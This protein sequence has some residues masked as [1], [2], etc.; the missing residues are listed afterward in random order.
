[1]A[2]I[3][4]AYVQIIPTAEGIKGSLTNIL[5]SE[6]GAAG[7]SAGSKFGGG[8]AGALGG[9]ATAAAGAVAATSAAVGALAKESVSAYADFEQLS[10]GVETLFG[11]LAGDVM[12]NADQ[13]F[14]TAGLSANEYMETVTSFAASLN[15]SLGENSWQAANYANTAIVSMADN[16]NKMG[17]SMES[18]QNAYQG[19][20]K[21][22]YTMLD[23]LKLGYGGTKQEME[24]LL[25][26]AEELEG[27]EVG[28]LDISNF[29]DIIDAIDIIQTNLG[30]AGTT[31]EEGTA[32]ISGSIATLQGAWTNLVAGFGNDSA[33]LDVLIG[34]V[35]ESAGSVLDNIMPI[36]EKVLSGI[37]SFISKAAP[38]LAQELPKLFESAL[39]PLLQAV[40]DLLVALFDQLPSILTSLGNALFPAIVS[41]AN[42]VAELIPTLL[43][44]ITAMV[45][46][47]VM[48]FVDNAG[49]MID[50]AIALITGLADGLLAS[51]P[52]L[53]EKAPEIIQKTVDALIANAPKLLLAAVQII[54]QLAIGLIQNIPQII[55]A[56]VQIIG[57]IFNAFATTNWLEVGTGI[58]R[59]IASGIT[60][61]VGALVDAVKAAAQKA[62]ES[63]KNFLGIHSPSAVFRD[64]I[65]QMIDLG[66]AEGIEKYTSPIKDAMGGLSDMGRNAFQSARNIVSGGYEQTQLA[67]AGFGNITIPVKIG[68]SKFGEATV[69]ANQ[70]NR[71]RSG[72]R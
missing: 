17:S 20:A 37:G 1:M 14:R 24:R 47:L 61:A 23:N 7:Q 60:G 63:A 44:Q 33:D 41:L 66:M 54:S 21:Q 43:P 57:S 12:N 53:L 9:M 56:A 19:F 38:I 35:V 46:D 59:G 42:S 62:L 29:A 50:A 52:V 58:I 4:K 10:G 71:Y 28:S 27:Y 72:G 67:P 2:D 6:A 5:D 64:D 70:I 55:S 26:D 25:R 49:D 48:M 68:D 15:S 3:A 69:K 51:L 40:T 8:M 22:N 65:G 11:D 45:L 16:A 18:I 31:M 39:P 30:I 36:L 32:T 34:N 13:A